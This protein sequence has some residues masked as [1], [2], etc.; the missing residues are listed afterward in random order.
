MSGLCKR[1]KC[2]LL[3]LSQN[4]DPMLNHSPFSRA[5]PCLFAHC[6]RAVFIYIITNGKCQLL[7]SFQK[8]PQCTP[9]DPTFQLVPTL[10]VRV[11]DLPFVCLLF[12]A[13][14]SLGLFFSPS[15]SA[16]TSSRIVCSRD[17]LQFFIV[18]VTFW[19]CEAMYTK[20]ENTVKWKSLN[21]PRAKDFLYL[22][23]F[24]YL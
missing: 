12:F 23:Y 2:G 21:Q 11:W 14:L 16:F 10:P 13:N 20:S 9:W 5:I 1:G 19:F 17:S 6:W 24:I 4:T 15:F 7:Y 22:T 18:N 3:S 8:A